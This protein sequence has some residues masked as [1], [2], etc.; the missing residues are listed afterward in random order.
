MDGVAIVRELLV[1]DSELLELVPNERIVAG[2]L[3]IGTALDAISITSVSRID[4]NIIAPTATR[5]VVERVQVTAQAATYPR[6]KALLR[7]AR[8]A[9]AD[10]IGSAAGLANVTVQ[11]DAAGPDFMDEQATIYMSSQDFFVG[12]SEIR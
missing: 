8:A 4:R 1:G 10:F 5:H 11:T 6:M 3:P 12:Y 9:A 7:A 2:V